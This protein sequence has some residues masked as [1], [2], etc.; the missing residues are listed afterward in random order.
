MTSVPAVCPN[1]HMFASG[2]GLGAG[3]SIS[4]E[5]S[6]SGP[7]PHCGLMGNI[8]DGVYEALTES[9]LELRRL[10]RTELRSLIQVLR[11][12]QDAAPET[13][14]ASVQEAVPEAAPAVQKLVQWALTSKG[15][16]VAAWVAVL[17]A[18]LMYLRPPSEP[19]APPP[20]VNVN[21]QPPMSE[22]AI[23]RLIDDELDR[24]MRGQ[25]PTKTAVGR[26]APCLCGSGRKFKHCHGG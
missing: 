6:I 10:G 26:N 13:I 8:A 24:L 7:C 19:G 3:A 23:R 17:I 16:S 14:V 22:D 12:T 2:I 25:E 1:G 21:V 5:G 20:I 18:I 4:V 9:L 11:R 15:A